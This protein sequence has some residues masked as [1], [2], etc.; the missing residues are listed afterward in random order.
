M[1]TGRSCH[2]PVATVFTLSWWPVSGPSTGSPDSRSHTRTVPSEL[3]EMT[4]G[5]S[6]HTG[7]HRVHPVVVAGESGPSTGSPD[8]RSHTRTVRS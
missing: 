8:S 7:R 4:T 6:C 5:R 3:P 2:T 1:T